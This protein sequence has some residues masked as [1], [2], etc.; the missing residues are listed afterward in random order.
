MEIKCESCGKAIKYGSGFLRPSE[1]V[2]TVNIN[3]KGYCKECA[4][5]YVEDTVSKIIITTT[6]N[7]DG[8]KVK[9]TLTLIVLRL[10]LGLAF[11]AN[12]QESFQT[13][14]V[15]VQQHLKRSTRTLKRLR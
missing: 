4:Q 11:L 14:L 9:G 8:Y 3:G 12:L 13:F 2:V 7:I 6:I 15:I 5:Q 1:E 10:L